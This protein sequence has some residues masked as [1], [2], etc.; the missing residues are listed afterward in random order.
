[1]AKQQYL[2]RFNGSTL[3]ARHKARGPGRYA[4]NIDLHMALGCR[5]EPSEVAEGIEFLASDRAS[6]ITGT[7]LLIATGWLAASSWGFY[8]GVPATRS[9]V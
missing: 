9:A 2:V 8:G 5:M 3:T 1:M 7:D 4:K 6:A